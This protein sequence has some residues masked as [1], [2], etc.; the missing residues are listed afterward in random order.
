MSV[1]CHPDSG[2]WPGLGGEGGF[3][4]V[5]AMVAMVVLSIGLLGVAGLQARALSDGTGAAMRSQ[6]ALYAYDIAERMR[7]NRGDALNASAPYQVAPG[8]VPAISL[9]ALVYNDLTD[10][11]AE[12]GDLPSGQ[13]GVELATLG[14]GRVKATI[15]VRWLEKGALEQIQVETLL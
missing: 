8:E 1:N 10:W 9:P 14:T 3:S 13:G 4:L 2:K 5:E 15:T 6:A 11:L 12:V 7:A